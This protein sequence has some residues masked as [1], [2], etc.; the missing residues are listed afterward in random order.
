MN[1][2][3]LNPSN[4]QIEYMRKMLKP[5][6]Y[7]AGMIEEDFSA[8]CGFPRQSVCRMITGKQEFKKK[9]FI[10]IF[11]VLDALAQKIDEP[12]VLI[13]ILDCIKNY[14]EIRNDYKPLDETIQELR[15]R[16]MES[17]KLA[18]IIFKLEDMHPW[19]EVKP[20]LDELH[21]EG[22][23]QLDGYKFQRE[24]YCWLIWKETD[25]GEHPE[26]K[27]ED[28]LKIVPV[29]LETKEKVQQFIEMS[30]WLYL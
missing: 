12:Q 21:K 29:F 8:L 7:A 20:M 18:E 28:L 27:G 1:N 10:V 26:W 19:K 22:V 3:I 14:D 30:D 13:S 2:F 23:L 25:F 16:S 11:T 9:H 17:K 6:I 24:T 4:D 15:R 5:A